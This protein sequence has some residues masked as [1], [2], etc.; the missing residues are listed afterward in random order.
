MRRMKA[1][2]GVKIGIRRGIA[3]NEPNLKTTW[4][5]A[6]VLG[7]WPCQCQIERSLLCIPELARRSHKAHFHQCGI[8]ITAQRTKDLQAL[9]PVIDSLLRV[10]LR[11]IEVAKIREDETLSM[12]IAELPGQIKCGAVMLTCRL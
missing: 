8:A 12:A 9:V 4:V 11:E 6:Q 10:P 1:N 3:R 2:Q 5:Q 7:R